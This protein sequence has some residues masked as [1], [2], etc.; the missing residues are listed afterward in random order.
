MKEIIEKLKDIKLKAVDAGVSEEGLPIATILA[1]RAG[2]A[3]VIIVP[4]SKGYHNAK[5]NLI[6]Y[7]GKFEHNGE[8]YNLTRM[9]KK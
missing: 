7:Y 3:T 5:G 9:V 6:R 8:Q 1:G 2:N 4:D